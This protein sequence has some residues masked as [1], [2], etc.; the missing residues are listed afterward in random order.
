MG[1]KRMKKK[2]R[3]FL[4]LVV[5]LVSTVVLLVLIDY[6]PNIDETEVAYVSFSNVSCISKKIVTNTEDIR[7][8]INTIDSLHNWGKYDADDVP[9]GGIPFHLVFDFGNTTRLISYNQ[10][11]PGGRGVLCDGDIQIKALGLNLK[12]LWDSLD[13]EGI[14]AKPVEIFPTD[15]Q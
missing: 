2:H 15:I 4:G 7:T 6:K 5:I 1:V 9:A 10:T 13:Y 11:G 8:I 3:F 12:E 14:E